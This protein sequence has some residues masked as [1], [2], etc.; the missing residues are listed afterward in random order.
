[1]GAAPEEPSQSTD[2]FLA[3]KGLSFLVNQ[4]GTDFFLR[5]ED[6]QNASPKENSLSVHP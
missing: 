6:N 3:F 5:K 4:L 1:M 2:H